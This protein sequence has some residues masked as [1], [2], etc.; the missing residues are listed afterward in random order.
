L[1]RVSADGGT[2]SEVTTLDRD[3]LEISHRFPRF[4]PDG[5]HLLFLNR[6]TTSQLTRYRITAVS[7][8][9]GPTKPLLDAMSTGVYDSGRLLFVRDQKLF[10]QPFDAAALVLSGEPGSSPTRSGPMGRI[11]GLVGVDVVSGVLGW[12]RDQPSAKVQWKD[13]GK[14]LEEVLQSG[15]TSA[16][17]SGD[18]RLIMLARPDVQMNTVGFVIVDHADGTTTPFTAPDTTSTSPVRSPTTVRSSTHSCATADT[19]FMSR[20]SNHVA[21][22][23][24]CC[25]PVR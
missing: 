8:T 4:L 9:G 22:S 11:A 18:G 21:T 10:A 13:A 7:V 19:I 2:P 6:I 17:P 14:I 5:R 1:F 20:R 23:G 16:T 25:I 3:K 24:A 15:E 12:R